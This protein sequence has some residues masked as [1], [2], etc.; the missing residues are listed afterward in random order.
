MN[1]S[2]HINNENNVKTIA[3]FPS[4]KY[5][6]YLDL[7]MDR[8]IRY[9][10]INHC[11][12]KWPVM[13]LS[14]KT[15]F[16]MILLSCMNNN[17]YCLKYLS[18]YINLHTF[19]LNFNL[20]SV[21][22]NH[23]IELKYNRITSFLRK[24]L[25]YEFKQH[26]H[27][28]MCYYGNNYLIKKFKHMPAYDDFAKERIYLH[29]NYLTDKLL[30][31]YYGISMQQINYQLTLSNDTKK[32][33]I[34]LLPDSSIN[35]LFYA[36]KNNDYTEWIKMIDEHKLNKDDIIKTFT[37]INSLRLKYLDFKEWFNIYEKYDIDYNNVVTNKILTI[38]FGTIDDLVHISSERL[39][40][41]VYIGENNKLC[42]Y[43]NKFNMVNNIIKDIELRE[44]VNYLM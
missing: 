2:R 44:F 37:N 25:C 6:N 4:K 7:L 36:F 8:N 14:N 33:Y 22:I 38:L 17:L 23:C 16:I 24:I 28:Y 1:S 3:K 5:A 42:E 40:M 34:K 30:Y 41:I 19:M 39:K 18:K 32:E 15:I 21:C 29:K 31:K 35:E 20:I 27:W 26:D 11:L 43:I 12:V 10:I 9:T 13:L